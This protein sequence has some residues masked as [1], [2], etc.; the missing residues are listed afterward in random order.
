[1]IT[2]LLLKLHTQTLTFLST[3]DEKLS[4]NYTSFLPPLTLQSTLHLLYH[5]YLVLGNICCF[6]DKVLRVVLKDIQPWF[7][8]KNK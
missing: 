4:Q 3:K 7:F 5:Y 6:V 2:H 8:F 1:M